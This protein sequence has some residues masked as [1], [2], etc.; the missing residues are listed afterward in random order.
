[1][2]EGQPPHADPNLAQFMRNGKQL[3][4]WLKWFARLYLIMYERKGHNQTR[5]IHAAARGI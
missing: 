3:T 1:M 2:L 5:L 4:S